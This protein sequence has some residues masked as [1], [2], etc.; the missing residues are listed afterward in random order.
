MSIPHKGFNGKRNHEEIKRSLA[1]FLERR[2]YI[3][4][5]EFWVTGT[6]HQ[7]LAHWMYGSPGMWRAGGEAPRVDLVGLFDAERFRFKMYALEKRSVAIE[8]SLTT[9]EQ[10]LRKLMKLDFG[11]KICVTE[12]LEGSINNVFILSLTNLWS[13]LADLLEI[14]EKRAIEEYEAVERRA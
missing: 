10:D 13:R 7:S 9:L 14:H 3:V 2:G 4:K 12:D 1:R 11:L 8:V 5:E 6:L